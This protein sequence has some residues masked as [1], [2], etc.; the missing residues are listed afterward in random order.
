MGDLVTR[1]C[2]SDLIAEPSDT[3]SS[4]DT[5]WLD[6]HG[7]GSG[8]VCRSRLIER[9][10]H[11]Q[12]RRAI[13]PRNTGKFGLR[14]DHDGAVKV[15][16]KQ[17]IGESVL[18]AQLAPFSFLKLRTRF[19]SPAPIIARWRLSPSHGWMPATVTLGESSKFDRQTPDPR[20][21]STL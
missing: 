19:A 21:I 8:P 14:T 9:V 12:A 4:V 15:Q 2:R 16:D 6:A 7:R 3:K 20:S 1:C 11:V 10:R 17:G 5:R 18:V 13:A